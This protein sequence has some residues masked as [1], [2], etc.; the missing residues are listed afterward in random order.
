MWGIT[1]FRVYRGDMRGRV[2]GFRLAF[3]FRVSGSRLR[4]QVSGV[5]V[6]GPGFR[7]GYEEFEGVPQDRPGAGYRRDGI[8]PASPYR[9]A[10]AHTVPIPMLRPPVAG[11]KLKDF[12]RTPSVST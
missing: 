12:Y 10:S 1:R 5:R 9:P 2:R 11:V 6:Q 4:V 8:P 3:G 7:E